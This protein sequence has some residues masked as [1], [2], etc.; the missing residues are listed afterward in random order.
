MREDLHL[1]RWMGD[2]I[3]SFMRDMVYLNF[4]FGFAHPNQ[5]M[6]KSIYI[7]VCRR[8]YIRVHL[9]KLSSVEND[10]SV[11]KKRV[12]RETVFEKGQSF[13]FSRVS[14]AYISVC[15]NNNQLFGK[16]SILGH[17]H[18]LNRWLIQLNISY[19]LVSFVKIILMIMTMMLYKVFLDDDCFEFFVL[20]RKKDRIE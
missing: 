5:S 1:K 7:I 13:F 20:Y 9:S 18:R 2:I 14:S 19:T 8:G 6:K 15:T 12:E 3:Y 16:H 17:D 11:Y 10:W 4:R